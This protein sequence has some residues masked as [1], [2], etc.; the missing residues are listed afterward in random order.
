MINHV[1]FLFPKIF[2]NYRDLDQQITLS[3]SFVCFVSVVGVV[4]CVWVCVCIFNYNIRTDKYDF[5]FFFFKKSFAVIGK[6]EGVRINEAWS[7]A[8]DGSWHLSDACKVCQA[9]K[10]TW[11]N[12]CALLYFVADWKG[13][14]KGPVR[15]GRSQEPVTRGCCYFAKVRISIT[16]DRHLLS[17][18]P[19]L[20]PMPWHDC[21][22]PRV[23]FHFSLF[24]FS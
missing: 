7:D 16:R 20:D 19:F 15:E 2:S 4:L 10:Q 3:L 22:L 21:L 17:R 6:W 23:I 13:P 11:A 24:S 9:M 5:T 18:L 1:L 14:K 8:T 12:E